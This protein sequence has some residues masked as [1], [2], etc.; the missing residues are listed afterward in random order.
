MIAIVPGDH[1]YKQVSELPL[2]D[3]MISPLPDLKELDLSPDVEFLVLACDGIW[4][5]MSSQEVVDFVRS[6]LQ[7]NPSKLSTI[8]EEVSGIF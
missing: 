8:C 1:V 5:F 7:K 4:N 3:Q 2:Q 6:R